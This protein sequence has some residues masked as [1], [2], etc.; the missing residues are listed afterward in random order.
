MH[1]Y[2]QFEREWAEYIGTKYAVSCNS[3]TSA[4]HLALMALRVGPGDE[5]ICPNFTMAA[6]PFA[7]AYTGAR[8]VFVDCGDDLNIDPLLVKEKINEKTKAIIVVHIYGR[9][10]NLGS[11]CGLGVPVIEDCA[12]A[13]GAT[14]DG[15]RV[16]SFGVLS[17]FSFYRNKILHA[18]EGGAV[19]TNDGRLAERMNY[20]KNMAFDADHTYQH[21]EIGYNYRMTNETAK[22]LV[23]QLP[24]ID[25]EIR[26][27][28]RVASGFRGFSEI[29]RPKGSVFWVK[30]VIFDTKKERDQAYDDMQGDNVRL[31][32]RPMTTLP[33]WK[34]QDVRGRAHDYSERGMYL[35]L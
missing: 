29:V 32:F 16:G 28:R 4:L 20:L 17:C 25:R 5:V 33:M 22:T 19:C 10:A 30:D 13:H 11:L 31:F 3:G 34:D 8:P 26:R 7:V 35:I 23:K 18:E 14:I 1:P 27:R 9:P 15:T 2:E 21:D 12:E 24:Y 6:V